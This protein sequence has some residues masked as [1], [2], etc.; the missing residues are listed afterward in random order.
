MCI[1]CIRHRPP[2]EPRRM[3]PF[4][5]V[6]SKQMFDIIKKAGNDT[7]RIKWGLVAM[8]S[9]PFGFYVFGEWF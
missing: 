1:L 5:E 8:V 6:E 2:G 4:S 9:I 7:A 3:G